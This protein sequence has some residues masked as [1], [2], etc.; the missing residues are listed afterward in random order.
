MFV[1]RVNDSSR[2]P[3]ICRRLLERIGSRLTFRSSCMSG[4]AADIFEIHRQRARAITIVE[5]LGARTRQGR[6]IPYVTGI[7]EKQDV[8]IFYRVT[9]LALWLIMKTMYLNSCV[10]NVPKF[11]SDNTY[12]QI[13]NLNLNHSFAFRTESIQANNRKGTCGNRCH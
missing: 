12:I 10:Y 8:P 1:N 6:A 2:F 13:L 4:G 3:S 11:F 5:D 7:H 9:R